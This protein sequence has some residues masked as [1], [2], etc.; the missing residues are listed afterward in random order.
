MIAGLEVIQILISNGDE[1]FSIA[2][3]MIALE[4][5][6]IKII[7]DFNQHVD[8]LRKLLESEKFC[9]KLTKN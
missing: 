8:T 1:I 4:V 7:L 3:N 2:R 9:N 5:N 6:A